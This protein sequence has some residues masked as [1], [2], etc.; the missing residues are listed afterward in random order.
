M[1]PLSRKLDDLNRKGLELKQRELEQAINEHL[2][3]TKP[4]LEKL[5]HMREELKYIT[6]RLY[7]IRRKV[8]P[9]F[10]QGGAPESGKRS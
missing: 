4:N 9:Q 3:I 6:L 8:I 2:T 5:A 7:R 10:V 1:S